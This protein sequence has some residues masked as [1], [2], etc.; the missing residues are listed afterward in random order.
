MHHIHPWIRRV[1]MLFIVLTTCWNSVSAQD[2]TLKHRIDSTFS[3]FVDALPNRAMVVGLI[4]GGETTV[5]TFG[6]L[7][8][9]EKTVFDIGS[10]TKVF[11]GIALSHAIVEEK[12]TPDTSVCDA[13]P[14]LFQ[15][16]SAICEVT[17]SELAA[18]HSGLP[19]LP[20][21]LN[22][23]DLVTNPFA[24]YTEEDLKAFAKEWEGHG[25][26]N[27]TY[28]YSNVGAGMMGLILVEMYGANNYDALLQEVM[29]EELDMQSTSTQILFGEDE[30]KIQGHNVL[31]GAASV[32]WTGEP[33]AG[34]GLLRSNT[35][36]MLTFLQAFIDLP[37]EPTSQLQKAMHLSMEPLRPLKEGSP[38]SVAYFWHIHDLDSGQRLWW[39]NGMTG[40]YS[41]YMAFDPEKKIG[42]IAM[43]NQ[44]LQAFTPK[45]MELLGEVF[46]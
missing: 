20:S 7:E 39:H 17:V 41:S 43:Y 34:M 27:P 15:A 8:T 35:E 3:P 14:Q 10:I 9:D 1:F 31:G 37:A 24:D 12:L 23:A 42:V 5:L 26:A 46:D 25:D 13:A 40:G 38:F 28:E 11:T 44:A 4:K 16:E 18:H 30:R 45:W 21:N 36:D 33:L 2:A 32:D 29:L 19:R 6:D 22:A